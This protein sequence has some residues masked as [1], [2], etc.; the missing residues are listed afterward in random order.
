MCVNVLKC[1]AFLSIPLLHV[2]TV[3]GEKRLM[4]YSFGTLW[5]L[6]RLV[7]RSLGSDSRFGP[8]I[9]NNDLEHAYT[10]TLPCKHNGVNT[11]VE[12]ESASKIRA[13][14]LQELLGLRIRLA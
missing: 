3:L 1:N 2:F 12:C 14:T 10:Q 6:L 5:N 4:C 7:D 9:D 11:A 8:H 13:S